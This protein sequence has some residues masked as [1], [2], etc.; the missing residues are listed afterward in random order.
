MNNGMQLF[1]FCAITFY[2]VQMQ[3]NLSFV[4]KSAEQNF[5]VLKLLEE[6]SLILSKNIHT[7]KYYDMKS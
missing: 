1:L 5:S 3:S 4:Q 2:A 6:F 7:E